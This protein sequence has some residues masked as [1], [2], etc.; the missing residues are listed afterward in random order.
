MRHLIYQDASVSHD[1]TRVRFEPHLI[2]NH[3]NQ[4][5]QMEQ[6]IQIH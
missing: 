2:K 6:H 3:Y 5:I 4:I 1:M